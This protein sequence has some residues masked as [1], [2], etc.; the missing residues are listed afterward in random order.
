MVNLEITLRALKENGISGSSDNPKKL[1]LFNDF[2]HAIELYGNDDNVS[3]I[4]IAKEEN[5]DELNVLVHSPNPEILKNIGFKVVKREY[6]IQ[7]EGSDLIDSK[8]ESITLAQC[9]RRI[10]QA[11]KPGISIG[12]SSSTGTLGMIVKTRMV[13][14]GKSVKALLTCDHVLND[15]PVI[16]PGFADGGDEKKN[17]VATLLQEKRIFDERGD[18]VLAKLNSDIKYDLG[19]C[20]ENRLRFK[21]KRFVKIGEAVKKSGRTTNIS[22]LK[23][24]E[25]GVF[26]INYGN[27]KYKFN[28]FSLIRGEGET[29]PNIYASMDSGSVVYAESSRSGMAT[30]AGVLFAIE[31]NTKHGIACHITPIFEDLEIDFI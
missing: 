6:T 20:G 9:N 17:M 23:V 25:I 18:I 24:N 15:D 3:G 2:N 16:Q 14:T 29:L 10:K 28:A 5:S 8:V 19:I 21:D 26:Y 4:T 12:D 31:K 13:R 22:R 27:R 7:E 30:A 11:L 1:S